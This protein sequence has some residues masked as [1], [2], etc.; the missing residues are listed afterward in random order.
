MESIAHHVERSHPDGLDVGFRRNASDTDARIAKKC[1]HGEGT[2]CIHLS[3]AWPGRCIGGAR[4]ER[5]KRRHRGRRCDEVWIPSK[6]NANFRQ[7]RID[8]A[9]RAALDHNAAWYLNA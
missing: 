1:L 8:T 9:Y 7:I 4:R 5:R 2:S 6:V 3:I